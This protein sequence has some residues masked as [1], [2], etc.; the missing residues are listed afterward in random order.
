MLSRWIV[1][2]DG[3]D[4]TLVDDDEW[5]SRCRWTPSRQCID[6]VDGSLVDDV[7]SLSRCRRVFVGDVDGS[8]DVDAWRDHNFYYY[9]SV[10]RQA[11]SLTFSVL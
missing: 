1:D 6:D 4:G 10:Y 8:L 9:E 5:L 2:V 7:E 3:V 11:F